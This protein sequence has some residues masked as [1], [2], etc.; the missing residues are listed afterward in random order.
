MCVVAVKH[1]KGIGWVGAKNRDRNYKTE[2]E[3]VQS[4]RD[5]V[6]RLFID[7][8]LSRWTEGINEHGLSIISAAFS[9]KSD[10]KEADKIEGGE[11]KKK[12]GQPGYYSPDGL[13]IRKALLLKDPEKAVKFLVKHEL[14][15]AT[16]VFNETDCYLLEAGFTVKKEDADKDN[17]R[18]YIYKVAH[19]DPAI[20][21]A[22]RTNHGILV[23]ELGYSK[24]SDDETIKKSRTSSEKR[25]QY[26][27]GALKEVGKDPSEVLD[28]LAKTPNKDPF[29]NPIRTGDVSKKELVTTGQLLMVPKDRTLHYR[30]LF[31]S[32]SFEYDKLNGPDAKTFF[33]IVSSRKLLSFKD[34][35]KDK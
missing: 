3:I 18:E 14:P 5:N 11:N 33:E 19:I 29:L 8:V 7:D 28:A 22:V 16:F 15:G 12:R 21:F 23:P 25:R 1:I 2:I 20:G 24:L 10:E 35:S 30:P 27:V 9:V 17:P 6:Q 34:W 32:V 13:K 31:S 4:N 26:A